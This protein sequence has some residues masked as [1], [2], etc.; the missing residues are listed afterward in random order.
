MS[1]S[2]TGRR[3]GNGPSRGSRRRFV[4]RGSR[5]WSWIVLDGSMGKAPSHRRGYF[6]TPAR[7]YLV[8]S[9]TCGGGTKLRDSRLNANVSFPAK[10]YTVVLDEVDHAESGRNR[11][12]SC[13]PD[14]L[15]TGSSPDLTCAS[16]LCKLGF[17]GKN[18]SIGATAPTASALPRWKGE[19]ETRRGPRAIQD[20]L[21]IVHG[22][23]GQSKPQIASSCPTLRKRAARPLQ[24]RDSGLRSPSLRAKER[25]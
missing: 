9:R 24:A 19:G 13:N 22:P 1:L 8:W 23:R 3:N 16:S 14:G 15:F 6:H 2:P 7:R 5:R 18:S 12:N 4:A 10:M 17:L 21:E 25:D 11:A 20:T